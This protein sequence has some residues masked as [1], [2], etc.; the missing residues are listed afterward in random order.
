MTLPEKAAVG[1]AVSPQMFYA[2]EKTSLLIYVSC[3]DQTTLLVAFR[4]LPPFPGPRTI[5]CLCP[6]LHLGCRP[7]QLTAAPWLPWAPASGWVD[8]W[9][10]LMGNGRKE[11]TEAGCL[12]PPP[13]S[14]SAPRPCASHSAGTPL[15][16]LPP[17]S[18][19]L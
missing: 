6:A 7:L 8:Q 5:L 4:H 3:W 2:R 9:E 10:A 16:A 15:S 18:S 14:Y 19:S 1:G 12:L 13:P 11:E 17:Q